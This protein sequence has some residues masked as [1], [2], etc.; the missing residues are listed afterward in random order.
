MLELKKSS[1]F[2]GTYSKAQ[3]RRR[4]SGRGRRQA[5]HLHAVSEKPMEIDPHVEYDRA[6]A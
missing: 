6:I 4:S 3:G 5:V 2:F 1:N